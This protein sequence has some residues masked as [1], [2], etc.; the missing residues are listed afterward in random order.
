MEELTSLG[1]SVAATKG[2]YDAACKR[3]LAERQVLARVLRE[4][5]PEF[6]GAPI[7]QIERE[8]FEAEP[9]LG[10]DAVGPAQRPRA[11]PALLCP[12]HSGIL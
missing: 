9:R 4:W 11:V 10:E 7:G 3:L 5:V 2:R 1:E 8:G 6:A 12:R